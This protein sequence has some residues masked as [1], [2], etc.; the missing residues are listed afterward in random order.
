VDRRHGAC[1]LDG[2]SSKLAILDESSSDK[3]PIV[4]V[5]GF[6]CEF[7]NVVAIEKRWR[8]A[9]RRLG[10]SSGT[11][12]KYSMSWPEPRLR[13]ELI[14]CIGRLPVSGVV[15]LLEDFRPRSFKLRKE[16]RGERYI[17][18]RAFEYVLQRLV[19]PQYCEP[20]SGPHLVVFDH[21]SDFPKLADHYADCHAKDWRFGDQS[22][23]SLRSCGWVAS[24][25]AANEGPLTEIADLIVSAITRWAGGRCAETRGKSFAERTELD[26]DL[27]AIIA[28]FPASPTTIPTRRQGFSVIT[29]TGNRT[30][31]ELLYD[32]VDH[33]L[34]NLEASSAA[35]NARPNHRPDDDPGL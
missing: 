12:V 25:T 34:N 20:N 21:R 23:P 6:V 10:L 17:H 28:R 7:D 15:A 22:I 14:A 29:H 1:I 30:G 32:N 8:N 5:G 3:H 2:V 16:T 33:W 13:N 24:L 31:K 11:P 9:K 35:T 19:A 27:R 26:T 18:L 4:S